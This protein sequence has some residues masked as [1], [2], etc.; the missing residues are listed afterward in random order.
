MTTS[1]IL[2]SMEYEI[3]YARKVDLWDKPKESN[4][5]IFKLNLPNTSVMKYRNHASLEYESQK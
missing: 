2:H 3:L 4:K 1:I 5:T